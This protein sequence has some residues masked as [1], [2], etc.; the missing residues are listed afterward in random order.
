MHRAL[1]TPFYRLM[2][3][4]PLKG[5]FIMKTSNKRV[6]KLGKLWVSEPQFIVLCAVGV[7]IAVIPG[8]LAS[9]ALPW[10]CSSIMDILLSSQLLN[11]LMLGLLLVFTRSGLISIKT[12]AEMRRIDWLACLFFGAYAGSSLGPLLSLIGG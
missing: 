1:V 9:R 4:S 8:M 2:M 12:E 5:A 6:V 7:V 11:T 10:P 3:E